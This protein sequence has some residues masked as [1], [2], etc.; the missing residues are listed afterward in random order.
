M[1]KTILEQIQNV[2]AEIGSLHF[3]MGELIA[4]RSELTQALGSSALAG[5]DTSVEW[6]KD[7]YDL[8]LAALGELGFSAKALEALPSYEQVAAGVN[9]GTANWLDYQCADAGMHRR[10][11]LAPRIQDI[12]LIGTKRA[13]G[14]ITRF[15]KEQNG[16]NTY[17][18]E[19]PWG[20]E[21]KDKAP[22]HDNGAP[23]KWNAGVL[24]GDTKDPR[25]NSKK[26]NGYEEPGLVYVGMTV[27]QQRKELETEIQTHK[28]AGRELHSATIGEIV[29]ANA[30]R[31]LEGK[32]LLGQR[33]C[34][35][36]V[37]YPETVVARIAC[38][39]I[40]KSRNCQ[41]RLSV[42][43]VDNEW[44]NQGVRRVLRIP[45]KA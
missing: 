16:V 6:L 32:P 33:T 39:P 42:S 27:P 8:N 30:Q 19:F 36:L 10:F 29:V 5:G 22:I 43:S 9:N 45:A 21:F 11:V 2:D 4:R 1:P 26:A 12:G 24:L 37:H 38:I 44:N 15:D 7:G 3:R 23:D 18:W 14:L 13:P 34:T 31:R 41:Q 17:V 40:V 28:Q 35:R 20:T 25:D